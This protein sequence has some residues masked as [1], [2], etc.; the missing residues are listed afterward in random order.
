MQGKIAEF[1]ENTNAEAVLLRNSD[2]APD[3]NFYYFSGLESGHY[4]GSSLILKRNGKPLLLTNALYSTSIAA[5]RAKK[6]SSETQLKKILEKEFKGIKK[7]G[8]NFDSYPKNSFLRLKKILPGKSFLDVSKAL[9]K[10]RETKTKEEIKKI[11]TAIKISESAIKELP[12]FF[13]KGMAEKQLALKLELLLREKGD[14]ELAFPTIVASAKNSS[15][16][17]YFTGNTKIKNGFLLVD[18]GAK[19]RNYC[20]DLSR[21][22]CVGKASAEQKE[23]YK[24]IFDAKQFAKELCFPGAD[25]KEIFGK[26]NSFLKKN[27]RLGMIHGLGHGLGLQVHDFPYGFGEK[28]GGTLKSGMV[29]TLEPAI[30]TKKFG[31]RIEDDILITKNGCKLLSNAP[32]ELVEL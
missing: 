32:E 18:F 24:K 30:Y 6:V 13:R 14:N 16:P 19:Y 11:E 20:S 25:R 7:I 5:L 23:L 26:T 28:T 22:F 12:V 10:T 15:V 27:T 3:A 1:F 31:I 17:H 9:G 8:L 4:S 29:L 21:M 2:S